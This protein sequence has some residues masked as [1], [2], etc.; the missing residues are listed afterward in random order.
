VLRPHL[1]APVGDRSTTDQP[2]N[3]LHSIADYRRGYEE[4][5]RLRAYRCP[6]CGHVAATYGLVCPACG[7]ADLTELELSG[8]GTV[9]AFTVQTV[10]SD[11]FL[12]EAPYAYVI[13]E[14]EEGGRVTGWMPAV[15]HETDLAIGDRV[16]WVPSYKTG[17]VFERV[18]PPRVAP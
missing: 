7:K 6:A 8:R 11:E 12:N 13:V 2:E 5:K 3:A 17:V 18:D 15:R 14:L 1:R 9:A 10:P 16:Q 4:E